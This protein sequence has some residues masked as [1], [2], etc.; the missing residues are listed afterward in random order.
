VTIRAVEVTIR[1]SGITGVNAID[2]N[3][4]R[5]YKALTGWIGEILEVV[6]SLVTPWLNY[7]I[8]L[9][10]SKVPF[11]SLSIEVIADH[12]DGRRIALLENGLI[13]KWN[14]ASADE[15]HDAIFRTVFCNELRPM[16]SQ[17]FA[18]TE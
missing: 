5:F 7:D 4:L 1:A 10:S 12:A 14:A 13:T 9:G 17:R 11:V 18:V 2:N 16:V 3:R 8:Y 6:P 15:S